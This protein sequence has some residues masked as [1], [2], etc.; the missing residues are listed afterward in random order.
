M[1]AVGLLVGWFLERGNEE[2]QTD[3]APPF[4]VSLIGGGTFSL[5]DH[6]TTDGRPLVLNLWASWCIPCRT[7]IPTIS[8]YAEANPEI[9]V[10]GVAVEDR[11]EASMQ[12]A[13]E[14]DASYPL[15]LG[16]E[17]FREDYPSIG[18]PATYF[19]DEGGAIVSIINGILTEDSLADA[20]D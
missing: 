14:V 1:V 6:L 17:A 2:Q 8:A 12:F 5:N 16:D 18:L 3:L 7:E 13:A 9:T 10:L 20:F 15:G 4:E 19:I 11:P